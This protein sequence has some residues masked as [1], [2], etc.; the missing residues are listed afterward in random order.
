MRS[1]TVVAAAASVS[2]LAAPAAFGGAYSDQV[3]AF[4]PTHYYRLDETT[5]GAVTDSATAPPALI[6]GTHEGQFPPAEVGSFGVPL[7][8]FDDGNRAIFNGNA[9]G[10]NL[11]P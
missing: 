4:N 7:P 11:G 8:G 2:A 9:G 3:E 1:A 6:H 5:R 10:V